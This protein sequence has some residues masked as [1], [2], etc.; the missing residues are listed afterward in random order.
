MNQLTPRFVSLF[1]LRSPSKCYDLLHGNR[2]DFDAFDSRA[3]QAQSSNRSVGGQYR[4][5]DGGDR[6]GW[7]TKAKA[8]AECY[9]AEKNG[10]RAKEALGC[11]EVGEVVTARS[12]AVRVLL[13]SR[14][15]TFI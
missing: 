14:I 5:W 3:G 11:V 13:R 8:R 9:G 15:T 12:P 4:E 7:S 2:T 6:L 10:P 1:P